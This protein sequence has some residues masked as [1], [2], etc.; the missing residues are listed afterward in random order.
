MMSDVNGVGWK[1]QDVICSAFLGYPVR[2]V[3]LKT[4]DSKGLPSDFNGFVNR[5]LTGFQPDC[6]ESA[7]KLLDPLPG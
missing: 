6:I 5:T 2:L 7:Q 1:K 3:P 4:H